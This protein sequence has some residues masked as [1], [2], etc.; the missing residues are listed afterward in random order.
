METPGYIA[1][2]RQAV[3]KRQMDVVANNLANM[4]TP[5]FRAKSVLFTAYLSEVDGGPRRGG[6]TIS[7][8]Q[9]VATVPDLA[10]GPMVATDNPLDL[11]IEGR[12]YFVVQTDNGER[13]TRYGAF[14]LDNQGQIVT[15]AGNPVLDDNNQPLTVPAGTAE[16]EVARDGTISARNP[17]NPAQ[18]LVVGRL[19]LVAFD[20]EYQLENEAGGLL[21]APANAAPAPATGVDI[22]QGTIEQSNVKSVVEMTKL[23]ETVRSYTAAGSMME[24][25]HERQRRAIQTLGSSPQGA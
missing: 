4:N 16:I 19:R 24:D 12:G 13:Y 20:N 7:M 18:N 1:L 15:S 23:I 11:A 25:E 17:A 22:L 9:D 5:A 10:E 8:V 6:G 21:R 2:S 3:M 14:K